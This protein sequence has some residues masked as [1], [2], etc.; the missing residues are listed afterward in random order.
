MNPGNL[1][2]RITFQKLSEI[3]ND[4]GEE[5]GTDWIDVKTVR[6]SVN[7]ISARE[8]FAAEKMNSEVSHKIYMRYIRSLKI[9]PDMR[10]KFGERHFELIGPPI[11]F[12]ER[13]VD[14]QLLCK[15]LF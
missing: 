13:N 11:N 8:F 7:P 2:H 9:T 4:Y 5:I 10:I 12:Q 15:E 3:Q 14:L 1:R 6:A